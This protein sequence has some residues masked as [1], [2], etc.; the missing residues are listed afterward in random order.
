MTVADQRTTAELSRSVRPLL[1]AA[2]VAVLIVI[3]AAGT[4]AVSPRSPAAAPGEQRLVVDVAIVVLAVTAL[5]GFA[6]LVGAFF[7]GSRRRRSEPENENADESLPAPW[8]VKLLLFGLPVVMLAVLAWLLVERPWFTDE[9]VSPS[10]RPS[11]T[12]GT[13]VPGSAG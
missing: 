5:A 8:W 7:P 12:A 6:G 10:S 13:A 4:G 9:A 11:V 3:V 1:F 2:V